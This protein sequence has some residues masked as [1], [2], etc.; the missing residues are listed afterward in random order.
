ML[1]VDKGDVLHT[2]NFPSLIESLEK[3]FGRGEI[4]VPQ[5]H[6]H[7]YVGNLG[8]NTST[9]L[10][11]PAWEEGGY[12]G[13]KLVTVSPDN[14]EFDLPSIQGVYLLMDAK[15]G[16]PLASIDAPSLTARRTAAASALASKLLSRKDSSSLLMIGTGS[17][18][19]ELIR[20]HRTVRSIENVFIWG[21]RIEKAESVKQELA[22]EGIEVNVVSDYIEYLNKVDIISCATLSKT[23]LVFGKHL[24]EGQHIDLVGAYKPDMREA[25]DALI[26]SVK[27]FVDSKTTAVKETGDLFIPMQEGSIT[28]DH[29]IDDLFGL[30][31]TGK[32]GRTNDQQITCFKSVGHALEDLVAARLVKENLEPETTFK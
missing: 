31:S 26:K 30:C 3:A 5:R 7:E 22:A 13:V 20:A 2:L 14:H 21:R 23:P 10:L 16:I 9:L 19:P 28:F 32:T 12:L 24:K 27:L 29:I 11:M 6:H 15:T 17:L 4:R 18:A 1:Q 25:D 8:K